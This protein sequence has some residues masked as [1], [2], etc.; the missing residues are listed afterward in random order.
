MCV[1][2]KA[3]A[4]LGWPTEA[5]YDAILVTLPR[6]RPFLPLLSIN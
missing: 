2:K 6:R 3:M 1:L 5:P 4:P